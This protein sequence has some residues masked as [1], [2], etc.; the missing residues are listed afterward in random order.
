MRT[1]SVP[2]R[3]LGLGMYER[4]KFEVYQ[5]QR[6]SPET[7]FSEILIFYVQPNR[8]ANIRSEFVKRVP[9]RYD[10]YAYTLRDISSVAL[11]DLKLDD[12]FHICQYIT[13]RRR[14]GAALV[15]RAI[16]GLSFPSSWHEITTPHNISF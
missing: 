3:R 12:V 6:R 16:E 8:L 15:E 7:K 10:R 5:H 13:A 11:G 9:L 4:G 14:R 2:E 1:T